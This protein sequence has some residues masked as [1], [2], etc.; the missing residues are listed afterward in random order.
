[1]NN[2]QRDK[3]IDFFGLAAELSRG[4]PLDVG[5]RALTLEALALANQF[6]LLVDPADPR[7]EALIVELRQLRAR[8]ARL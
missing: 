2:T 8:V 4:T 5:F 3:G 7:V 1:M 6:C